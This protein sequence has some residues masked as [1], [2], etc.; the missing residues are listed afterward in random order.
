PTME[1]MLSR[2]KYDMQPINEQVL[3]DQQQVADLL[4]Q[5]KIVPKQVDVR[6]AT[7]TSQQYAAIIPDSI[8][9]RA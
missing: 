8:R 7:L 1:T 5:L 3:R 9:N 4:Y 6:E 2:R